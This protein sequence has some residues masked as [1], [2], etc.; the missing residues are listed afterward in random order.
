MKRVYG[1]SLSLVFSILLMG[2]IWLEAKNIEDKP[3]DLKELNKTE[4]SFTFVVTADSH[5]GFQRKDTRKGRDNY[6]RVVEEVIKMNPKPKF[7]VIDGDIIA[8]SLGKLPE[9]GLRRNW[10]TFVE[11][12]RKL[13]D[14]G[15][16]PIPVRGNHDKIVPQRLGQMVLDDLV[17][18]FRR[19]I[20]VDHE[21]YSFDAG[22]WH[23]VVLPVPIGES[24]FQWLKEDLQSHASEPTMVFLHFNLLP[25]GLVQLEYYTYPKP[26]LRRLVNIIRSYGNV[27]YVVSGHVHMGIKASFKTVWDYE[28]IKFM[29]I[30]ALGPGARPFGEEFDNLGIQAQGYAIFKVSGE[31]VEWVKYKSVKNNKVYTYPKTTLKFSKAMAQYWLATTPMDRYPVVGV[32]KIVNGDFEEGLKGWFV[33]F[34]YQEDVNPRAIVEVESD[35]ALSGEKTLHLY[36][37]ARGLTGGGREEAVEAFQAIKLNDRRYPVISGA[38]RIGRYN[39]EGTNGAFIRV[40]VFYKNTPQFG[41]IYFFGNDSVRVKGRERSILSS[42]RDFNPFFRFRAYARYRG[43]WGVYPYRIGIA[44]LKT[45]QDKWHKFTINLGRDYEMIRGDSKP[46]Y[47]ELKLDR[48]VLWLGAVN[49]NRGDSEIE[50]WFDNIGLSFRDKEV[51]SNIDGEMVKLQIP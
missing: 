32:N 16:V 40:N 10:N 23:F 48:I 8:D 42:D 46:P 36:S 7:L 39:P 1:L 20:D 14:N 35:N 34:K 26:K 12:S 31:N 47:E 19:L 27:K 50:V 9:E 2:S 43:L 28:G 22:K 44:N 51:V 45:W 38:I 21:Y 3:F 5:I 15:I 13:L 33:P 37:R 24:V 25:V 11:I 6:R 18:V 4:N 41:L 29:V 30:P 17:G 49:D